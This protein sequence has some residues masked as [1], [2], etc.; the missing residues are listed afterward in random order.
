MSDP[1][2]K[3]KKYY[4]DQ[5]L[6]ESDE[7]DGFCCIRVWSI[8][9]GILSLLGLP[10]LIVGVWALVQAFSIAMLPTTS[11]IIVSALLV[12]V[13]VVMLLGGIAHILFIRF[14]GAHR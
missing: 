10:V 7:S 3:E 9:P 14:S 11:V 4:K 12:I 8:S 5:R 6:W 1:T 2:N 13:G